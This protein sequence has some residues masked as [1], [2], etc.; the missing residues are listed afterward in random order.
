[1]RRI[2]APYSSRRGQFLKGNIKTY[3]GLWHSR[4]WT[5]YFPAIFLSVENC[6]RLSRVFHKRYPLGVSPWRFKALCEAGETVHPQVTGAKITKPRRGRPWIWS[7]GSE[8]M[9]FKTFVNH[10]W[11]HMPPGSVFVVQIRSH[12]FKIAEPEDGANQSS[13]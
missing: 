10:S 3:T 4:R 6:F 1:M 11:N 2:P 12:S 9:R 8:K 7:H 5:M 13:P